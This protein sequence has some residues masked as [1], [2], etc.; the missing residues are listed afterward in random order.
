VNFFLSPLWENG[1]INIYFHIGY[2]CWG[3]PAPNNTPSTL[4]AHYDLAVQVDEPQLSLY[5]LGTQWPGRTDDP[6]ME[7]TVK[8]P[9]ATYMAIVGP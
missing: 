9:K 4:D 6:H 3:Q 2:F 7:I 1:L 5:H 8:T